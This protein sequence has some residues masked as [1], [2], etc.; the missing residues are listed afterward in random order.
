M[1]YPS[2]GYEHSV[3][4]D[5]TPASTTTPP[6][7]RVK[8]PTKSEKMSD[9]E[10]RSRIAHIFSSVTLFAASQRQRPASCGHGAHGTRCCLRPSNWWTTRPAPRKRVA[11]SCMVEFLLRAPSL[12]D[13]EAVA[14]EARGEAVHADKKN[15]Q[16]VGSRAL[17]LQRVCKFDLLL[18]SALL[19]AFALLYVVG[20]H[21]PR[22]DFLTTI[23]RMIFITLFL[24]L[25]LGIESAAV[26]YGEERYGL[27]LKVVRQIDTVAGLATFIGYLLLLVF[28]IVPAR[29]RQ[30]EAM[31]VIETE[32][33]NSDEGALA[34]EVLSPVEPRRPS[35]KVAAKVIK[36][37][38]K[39]DK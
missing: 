30:T 5:A 36:V 9:A 11:R 29:W 12:V 18:A 32:I 19:A 4:L 23:D 39:T 1:V 14:A 35:R 31:R 3:A 15:A 34:G 20:D 33:A 8:R 16:I 26:Y 6:R 17:R 37:A 27:S 10:I 24:L 7:L 13:D 25:W 28:I 22:V 21:V 2:I 38:S